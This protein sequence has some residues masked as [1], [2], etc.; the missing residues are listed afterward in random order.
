MVVMIQAQKGLSYY[1][2]IILKTTSLKMYL[3]FNR[4]IFTEPQGF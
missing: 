2:K 3:I 1:T 4:T